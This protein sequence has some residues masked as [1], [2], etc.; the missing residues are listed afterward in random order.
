MRTQLTID[1]L[2]RKAKEMK[3][4]NFTHR[5]PEQNGLWEQLLSNKV[6]DF[7]P[8]GIALLDTN[9]VLRKCNKL[10]QAYIDTYSHC[11]STEI[12]G[13]EYFDY[14]AGRNSP[15]V[16]IFKSVRDCRQQHSFYE[17]PVPLDNRVGMDETFWDA[18]LIPVKDSRNQ[19]KGLLLS[20]VDI[21]ES[22]TM[23]IQLCNQNDEIKELKTTIKTL[24]NLN[25]ENTILAE[26]KIAV[27]MKQI[28]EPFMEHLKKQDLNEGL[29]DNLDKIESDMNNSF[30]EF[31]YLSNIKQYGLTPREI[32]VTALI[33]MGKTTKDIAQFFQISTASIDFHRKNIRFK[34]KLTHKKVNLRSY[35]SFLDDQPFSR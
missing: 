23:A 7:L 9:F 5:F 1:H 15:I 35:L 11:S 18:K 33:K 32:Q 8:V 25:H 21:T 20:C 14:F 28:A 19:I 10:Y 26:Q 6:A 17:Y 27:N 3:S 13:M 34:L 29:S 22:A 12:I 31:A 2:V 16:D 4:R 30:N 24:M